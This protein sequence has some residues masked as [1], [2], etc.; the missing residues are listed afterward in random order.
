MV[1]LYININSVIFLTVGNSG[2]DSQLGPLSSQS[3]AFKRGW[4]NP[5]IGQPSTESPS[6][7]SKTRLRSPADLSGTS[8]P[9]FDT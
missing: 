1:N 5:P 9:L 3:G 4:N 8:K 2:F 7:N 6:G